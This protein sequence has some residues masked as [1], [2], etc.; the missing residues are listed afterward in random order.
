MNCPA[1]NENKTDR[2]IR[3]VVGVVSL[4]AGLL[5]LTGTAQIIALIIAFLGLFT[6]LTGFC[7]LY[8]L[9]GISTKNG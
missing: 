8:R 6:G 7:L 2:T 3:L 4:I 5:V 1:P 9:L